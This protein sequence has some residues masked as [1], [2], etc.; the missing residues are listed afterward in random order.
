[1]ITLQGDNNI[2]LRALE[3]DD[4]D[5]LYK[6]ENDQALWQV[7]N[8]IVPF[9]KYILKKYIENSHLDIYQSKQLRLIVEIPDEDIYIPAGALD[10]FDFDPFHLRAGLGIFLEKGFRKN[11]IASSALRTIISYCFETLQLN[12]IYCNISKSNTD[13]IMLFTHSGFVIKGDKSKWNK[14]KDGWE[15]ELFLQL[16]NPH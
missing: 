12:Q 13:S 3:P 15:D 1:M 2:R 10:I 11:G 7:S 5:L 8:T 14:T 9:S 6:W 16:L 4:I